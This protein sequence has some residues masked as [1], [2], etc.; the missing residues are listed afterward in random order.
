MT[1]DLETVSAIV[2][3]AVW[4][5]CAVGFGFTWGRIHEFNSEFWKTDRQIARDLEQLRAD[6]ARGCRRTDGRI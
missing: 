1:V 5:A 4:T 2:A 3:L 6:I